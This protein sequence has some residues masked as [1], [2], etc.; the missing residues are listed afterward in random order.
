M[1]AV[2]LL[3]GLANAQVDTTSERTKPLPPAASY[4]AASASSNCCPHSR[5]SQR[6]LLDMHVFFSPVCHSFQ[7][8]PSPSC[9]SRRRGSRRCGKFN[10][11]LVLVIS[12]ACAAVQTTA[13]CWLSGV[14]LAGVG[15]VRARN[16]VFVVVPQVALGQR[17][18]YKLATIPS[19]LRTLRNDELFGG[20]S[21][22]DSDRV[23]TLSLTAG[24]GKVEH[25]HA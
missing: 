1:A 4:S 22:I 10:H 23:E 13:V 8:T 20:H 11:F 2:V 3:V 15:G 5:V 14:R 19:F 16:E 21:F 7:P 18:S 9:S 24:R 12:L 6:A 25:T 17:L